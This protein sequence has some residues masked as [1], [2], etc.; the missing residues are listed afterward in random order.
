ME[1]Q[2]DQQLIKWYIKFK[3]THCIYNHDQSVIELF[4]LHKSYFLATS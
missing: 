4:K 3:V 2:Q 1:V